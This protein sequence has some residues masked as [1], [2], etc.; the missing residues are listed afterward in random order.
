MFEFIEL[1]VNE[2]LEYL[3]LENKE[4]EQTTLYQPSDSKQELFQEYIISHYDALT[5]F[6]NYFGS[7]ITNHTSFNSLI[8]MLDEQIKR[9]S[10]L[11]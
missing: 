3:Q 8:K 6:S 5:I 9:L 1:H 10:L 2:T 4:D 11:K 7:W